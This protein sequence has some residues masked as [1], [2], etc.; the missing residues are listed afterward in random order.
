MLERQTQSRTRGCNPSVTGKKVRCRQV[1][2]SLPR[3]LILLLAGL[4]L[5]STPGATFSPRHLQAQPST[6]SSQLVSS[7]NERCVHGCHLGLW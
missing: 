4:F 7:L 6:C 1:G 3:L 5:G 2:K